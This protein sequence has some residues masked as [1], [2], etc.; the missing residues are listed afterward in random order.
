MHPKNVRAFLD[1]AAGIANLLPQAERLIK[2]RQIYEKLVPK[3]L[4]K[5]SA[6]VNYKQ[7]RIVIFAENSSTAAK[8]KLL[9]PRL[10]NDFCNFGVEVTEI[11]L[12]V[13]PRQS[14]HVKNDRKRVRLGR[15]ASESL[16]ALAARLPDSRLRLAVAALA[17]RGAQDEEIQSERNDKREAG[18]PKVD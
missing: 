10:I 17:S 6:I 15:D 18:P 8:L 13:Q 9:T 1:S 12:D 16:C 4:L 7:Q 14:K 2:L 11:R 5:S 3:L